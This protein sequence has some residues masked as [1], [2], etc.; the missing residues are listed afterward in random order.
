MILLPQNTFFKK[1]EII[2]FR[3]L[4]TA[5]KVG[6]VFKHPSFRRSID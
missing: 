1:T 3:W 6:G 5:K 4:K 2:E